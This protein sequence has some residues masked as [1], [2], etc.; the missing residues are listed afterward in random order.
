[1]SLAYLR[2]SPA[3][4]CSL[5]MIESDAIMLTHHI[6]LM[7]HL[8]QTSPAYLYSAEVFHSRFPFNAVLK[9]E[10]RVVINSQPLELNR[11]MQLAQFWATFAMIIH[12]DQISTKSKQNPANHDG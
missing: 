12:K 9:Y 7:T 5:V 4:A 11:N 3:V 10:H 8:R 1:M 6:Q 2:T